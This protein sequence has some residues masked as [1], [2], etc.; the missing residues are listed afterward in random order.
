V[1]NVCAKHRNK[2]IISR[3]RE[4]QKLVI[5]YTI[6]IIMLCGSLAESNLPLP[7][8]FLILRAIKYTRK[9]ELSSR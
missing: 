9:N 1:A 4:E 2:F 3:D 6:K 8:T 7:L 5:L